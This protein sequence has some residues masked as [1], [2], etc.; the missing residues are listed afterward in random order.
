MGSKEL[1]ELPEHVEPSPCGEPD[2]RFRDTCL[3][4]LPALY[5]MALR[6]TRN[7][8]DAEDLVQ[9]TYLKAVKSVGSFDPCSECK[10]WLFKIMTNTFIDQYRKTAKGPTLVELEE[11]DEGIV[12][13]APRRT[14]WRPVSAEPEEALFAKLLDADINKALE[15]LPERFRM[16]ILLFDVEGFSYAEIADMMGIPVG[17]VMSR[18][19]RGRRLLKKALI[20]SARSRGLSVEGLETRRA[21]PSDS[22]PRPLEAAPAGARPPDSVSKSKGDVR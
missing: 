16:P 21:R 15:L 5:A 8:S 6:L 20:E 1:K 18:L 11:G 7:A 17:T 9:E 13:G 4:F 12:A 22:V 10:P 3:R 2:L 14:S 19:Y